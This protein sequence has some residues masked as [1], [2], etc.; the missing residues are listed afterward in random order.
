[1]MYSVFPLQV[2]LERSFWTKMIY[3][4]FINQKGKG[5]ICGI[6]GCHGNTMDVSEYID[7]CKPLFAMTL[8]I[9]HL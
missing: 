4:I 5:A 1:M 6:S 2:T 7:G 3:G 9:N 8:K